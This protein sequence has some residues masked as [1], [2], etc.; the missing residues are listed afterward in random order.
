[1]GQARLPCW[2]GTPSSL[3]RNSRGASLQWASQYPHEEELCAAASLPCT[4]VAH[5]CAHTLAR[6]CSRRLFPPC[7]GLSCL[8]VYEHGVK[9]CLLVSA[10]VS[11]A[12]LDTKELTTPDYVP[13]T[14]DA[15]RWASK[16]LGCSADEVAAL[17]ALDLKGKNLTAKEHVEKLSLLIGRAA[18]V[19]MPKL[20]VLDA[21]H[22]KLGPEG[23]ALLA[24]GLAHGPLVSVKCAAPRL[25]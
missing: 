4:A 8:D 24:A 13:G 20:T 11:T 3:G 25:S 14:A 19:A 18:K 9:R 22:T 17:E 1:M 10:Q 15:L 2:A 16:L 5:T 12:R 23:A 6:T 21:S 7:T